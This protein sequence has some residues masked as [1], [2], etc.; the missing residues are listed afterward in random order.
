VHGKG[1]EEE[2]EAFVFAPPGT[3][4]GALAQKERHVVAD[5]T[6]FKW[7]GLRIPAVI[8]QV[9]SFGTAGFESIPIKPENKKVTLLFWNQ[10]KA[11]PP[12]VFQ[13]H[14]FEAYYQLTKF[15]PNLIPS[16]RHLSTGS[17][18][19]LGACESILSTIDKRA[20]KI[21]F[22]YAKHN[23]RECDSTVV[24]ATALPEWK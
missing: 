23:I 10:P 6:M 8:L 5:S 15:K 11:I 9:R 21:G 12:S 13:S 18:P 19:Y 20:N 1:E 4:G 16:Q 14:H 24:S 7:E 2:V 17:V 22:V 3:S